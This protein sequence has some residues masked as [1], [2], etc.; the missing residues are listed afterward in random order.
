MAEQPLRTE[1]GNHIPSVCGRRAVRLSRLGMALL[2][3]QPCVVD[4]LPKPL[5]R[6]LVQ[7]DDF[8]SP[9]LTP[10]DGAVA[11]G[12]IR[13]KLWVTPRVSR[14]DKNPVLPDDRRRVG[15]PFQIH[16]PKDI[17]AGLHVPGDGQ[18]S[19]TEPTAVETAE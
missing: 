12:W 17:A 9:R 19:V 11:P 14:C 1:H 10:F 8:P 13:F 15:E 4:F 16:L 6:A 7:A 2:L 3:G 18:V 5:A